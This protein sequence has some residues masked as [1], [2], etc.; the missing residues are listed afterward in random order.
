MR[1][2]DLPDPVDALC[3][4]TDAASAMA[5][6]ESL[7]SEPAFARVAQHAANWEIRIAAAQ[8]ISDSE[9]LAQVLEA[10]RHRDKRV[11]R[12]CSDL[13]RARRRTLGHA[14]RA[15]ELAAAFRGILAAQ[16]SHEPLAAD[17]FEEL[18][19][20]LGELRT[21]FS[22]PPE[23]LELA[24]KVRDR[25]QRDVEAMRDL[26]ADAAEA[27]SLCARIV[28]GVRPA[29]VD[30][31]RA[32][33]MEIAERSS[34]RVAWLSGN[35]TAAALSHSLEKAG[36]VLDALAPARKAPEPDSVAPRSVPA[37]TKVNV[38]PALPAAERDA[39]RELLDGLALQIQAGQLAEAEETERRIAK[40]SKAAPLPATMLRRLRRE[41]SQLARL[42]GWARWGNDQSREQ[43]IQAA[44]GLLKGERDAEAQAAAVTA[45]REQWKKQDANEPANRK[46][47]ERFD[48]ILTRAFRPVLEFRARRAI[49]EKAAAAAKTLLLE[50]CAAW[51]AG[52]DWGR[53]EIRAIAARRHE[54][55]AQ[56]RALRFAGFR[57]ERQLRKRFDTLLRELD[58]H[59]GAARQAEFG[60]REALIRDAEALR[61][62][63]QSN[64][65]LKSVMVL[66]EQWKAGAR[67]VG[68]SRQEEQA[69]WQRFHKVC[70]AVFAQRDVQ[71]KAREAERAARETER[72]TER[73]TRE[74]ERNRQQNERNTQAARKLEAARKRFESLARDGAQAAAQASPEMLDKGRVER[75][76][77]LLDLEIALDLP[78][79]ASASAARRTRQLLKLQER[80]R[81]GKTQSQHPEALAE[82]WYATPARSDPEHDARMSAIVEV[83]IKASRQ[84]AK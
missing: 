39:I 1:N 42:R 20:E 64:N 79:P 71:R 18:D 81:P 53:A 45:L 56:W 38:P 55:G 17:R 76:A 40:M 80:F 6:L 8:R 37:S 78:S 72:V 28:S 9:I 61:D 23:C 21:E 31:H 74:A 84:A 34:R 43:L 32:K 59:I 83:L 49:E 50:Q 60:R 19:S 33:L 73:A 30:G 25:I 26:G 16:S 15:A 44:E 41:R 58:R 2:S 7:A 13:L 75:E 14:M 29:D 12:H 70:N 65:T 27:E 67:N 54:M 47:W 69:L 66:Q 11:F 68:L 36:A 77:L 3:A 22:V 52:I 82:R 51:S 24:A 35:P 4:A 5:L 46:H 57:A 62:A 10:T 48:A 63:P